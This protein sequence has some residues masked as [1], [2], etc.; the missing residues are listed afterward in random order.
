MREVGTDQQSHKCGPLAPLSML[1]RSPTSQAIRHGSFVLTPGP[2]PSTADSQ[3]RSKTHGFFAARGLQLSRS[4]SLVHYDNRELQRERAWPRASYQ[5]AG[6]DTRTSSPRSKCRL[7]CVLFQTAVPIRPT[8]PNWPGIHAAT[9]A[10]SP[11]LSDC[12]GPIKLKA[13]CSIAY[14]LGPP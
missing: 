13:T 9:E 8:H 1:R 5:G 4:S 14:L 2:G 12:S 11:F 6:L 7:E 10:A 3:T